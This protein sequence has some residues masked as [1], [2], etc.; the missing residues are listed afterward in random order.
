MNLSSAVSD[1]AIRFAVTFVRGSSG[2]A[3]KMSMSYKIL[4]GVQH[5]VGR[6]DSVDRVWIGPVQSNS[7]FFTKIDNTR[8]V[9]RCLELQIVSL[10]AQMLATSRQGACHNV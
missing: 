10:S 6:F 4:S 9:L 2:S 3:I 1:F 7:I 5:V 8:L